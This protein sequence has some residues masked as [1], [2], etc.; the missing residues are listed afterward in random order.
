MGLSALRSAAKGPLYFPDRSL[1]LFL[2]LS[3]SLSLYLLPGVAQTK[4]DNNDK[5]LDNNDKKL[6]SNDQKLANQAKEAEQDE[7]KRATAIGKVTTELSIQN[8][9]YGVGRR[10]RIHLLKFF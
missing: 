5:K 8:I 4:L 10:D 7:E 3:L 9:L 6:A 1:S 2:P